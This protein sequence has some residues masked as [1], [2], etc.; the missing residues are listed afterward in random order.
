MD[1]TRVDGRERWIKRP[2]VFYLLFFS[3]C[4]GKKRKRTP[5]DWRLDLKHRS[6]ANGR[7]FASFLTGREMDSTKKWL[8]LGLASENLTLTRVLR[9]KTHN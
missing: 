3:L 8:G 2:T 1:S 5:H 6:L 9:N 4:N 7:F